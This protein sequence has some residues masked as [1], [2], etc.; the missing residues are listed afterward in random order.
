MNAIFL[1]SPRVSDYGKIDRETRKQV[2]VFCI[3]CVRRIVDLIDPKKVVF[4]GLDT[5]K[6]FGPTNVDLTNERGDT[7]TRTGQVGDRGAIAVRHLT[8]A[9]PPPSGSDLVLIRERVL[10]Y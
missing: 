10:D 1:R 6:L 2:A 5:L 3:P 4:I 8:G 7:L 9:H